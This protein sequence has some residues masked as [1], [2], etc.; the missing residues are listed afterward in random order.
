VYSRSF[1]YVFEYSIEHSI[2]NGIVHGIVHGDEPHLVS[3]VIGVCIR[4]KEN[5]N[6][7]AC[8]LGK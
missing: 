8:F 3:N 6:I 2:V 1:E 5:K 4:T 7:G